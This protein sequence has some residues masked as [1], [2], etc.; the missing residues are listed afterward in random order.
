M[1]LLQPT[2]R[3]YPEGRPANGVNKFSGVVFGFRRRA[4]F[5]K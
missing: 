3:T 4:L 2:D 5:V 1:R